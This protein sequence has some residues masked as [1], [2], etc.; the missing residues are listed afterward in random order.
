M[1]RKVAGTGCLPPNACYCYD[2][3]ADLITNWRWSKWLIMVSH[4]IFQK[5]RKEQC[6]PTASRHPPIQLR[7]TCWKGKRKPFRVNHVHQ[8][9][10]ALSAD[11]QQSVSLEI[12]FGLVLMAL[13]NSCAVPT[14]HLLHTVAAG[15]VRGTTRCRRIR[16]EPRGKPWV[17]MS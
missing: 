13:L 6:H 10:A 5:F 11:K 3:C 17:L 2:P 12:K 15:A 1:E 14:R 8:A 7:Q 9:M 4:H 16:R